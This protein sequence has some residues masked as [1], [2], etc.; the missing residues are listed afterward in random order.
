MYS[1]TT[2]LFFIASVL[3]NCVQ[4]SRESGIP[5]TLNSAQ[6][7]DFTQDKIYG[8]RLTERTKERTQQF[9]LF[10]TAVK[11]FNFKFIGIKSVIFFHNLSASK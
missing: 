7:M 5:G 4:F 2:H 10:V 9:E 6:W 11:L 3:V 8:K 1:Q